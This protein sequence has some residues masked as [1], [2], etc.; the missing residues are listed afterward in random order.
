VQ[1]VSGG[2]NF[3]GGQPATLQCVFT[4]SQ[5]PDVVTWY[6]NDVQLVDS[7]SNS[8]LASDGSLVASYSIPAV[9]VFSAGQYTCKGTNANGSILGPVINIAVNY[10]SLVIDIGADLLV[11][12]LDGAISQSVLLQASQGCQGLFVR[13]QETSSPFDGGYNNY[14]LFDADAQTITV[15][16]VVPQNAVWSSECN[17]ANVWV[18]VTLTDSLL[19]VG[20]GPTIGLNTVASYAAITGTPNGFLAFG[21]LGAILQ[22]YFLYQPLP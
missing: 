11:S 8:V 2:G 18:W 17:S 9:G 21:N 4:A 6:L 22:S 12:P 7:N 15:N 20:T 5:R 3:Q 14:V 16:D 10:S 13:F 19:S 1:G